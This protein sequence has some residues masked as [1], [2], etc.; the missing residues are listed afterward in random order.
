[1][2]TNNY[3]LDNGAIKVIAA[4]TENNAT[5]LLTVSNAPSIVSGSFHNLTISAQNSIK[6]FAGNAL[7]E[8][9][10]VVEMGAAANKGKARYLAYTNLA[11][12]N[13]ALVSV[14]TNHTKFLN[15]SPDLVEEINSF[16]ISSN[17]FDDYGVRVNGY[18]IPSS[19]GMYQFRIYSDDESR[20]YLST[21]ESP[22]NLQLIVRYPD[23]LCCNFGWESAPV[24]LEANKVYYFES[25]LKEG[26]STDYLTVSWRTPVNSTYTTIPGENLAYSILPSKLIKIIQQ[27]SDLSINEYGDATFTAIADSIE[28]GVSYKW[29]QSADGQTW[30]D[31]SG[32]NSSVL[33]LFQVPPSANGT[34][35]R[36]IAYTIVHHPVISIG[37]F[38]A[39]A[40]SRSVTLSVITDT[41]P[42]RLLSATPMYDSSTIV[43]TF[44]EY[45]S[46][47]TALD[48]SN[49]Q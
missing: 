22:D 4:S 14:L 30:Q 18:L 29:Q 44:S 3:L 9:N 5:V 38:T 20:F 12:G 39:T 37:D 7:P 42:P 15:N 8:T 36:C 21:D 16:T 45:V 47:A 23:G 40:T 10:V 13:S 6:D 17:R 27:P 25:L 33:T 24:K 49:Y 1:N 41:E 26:S 35:Y 28:K 2:N 46:A 34:Q 32:A 11:T 48:I 31:I 19:T 43:L